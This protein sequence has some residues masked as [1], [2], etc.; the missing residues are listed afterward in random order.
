[1]RAGKSSRKELRHQQD[2]SFLSVDNTLDYLSSPP[3]P[4]T[5]KLHSMSKQHS[6]ILKNYTNGI[7]ST[8]SVPCDGSI[9]KNNASGG[10]SASTKL[11]T[12]TQEQFHNWAQI[13]SC[14][15]EKTFYPSTESQIIKI[16][17]KAKKYNKKLK[18]CGSGHSPS[19]IAMCDSKEDWMVH[20]SKY[21]GITKI[22]KNL[23]QIKGGTTLNEVNAFLEKK[24]KCLSSLG[25]ISEQTISGAI[26]TGTH[27]TG[28]SY[29]NLCSMVEMMRIVDASGH[30][31]VAKKGDELWSAAVCGLGAVG[32]ICEVTF[33]VEPL[34][35]LYAIQKPMP[36]DHVLGNLNDL[37]NSAEHYRFWWFPHT[38]N[39]ISWSANRVGM[40]T[41][42]SKDIQS[43]FENFYEN[44]KDK[45]IGYHLFEF[46]L[47][48][49]R[50]FPSLVPTIN[51]FYYYA[52]F[53]EAKSHVDTS[54]RVFNF[55]C[56]FK[57]YVNEWA[58]PI[59]RTKEALLKLKQIIKEEDFK[60]H[61]PVEVRFVKRDN[62]WMSPSYDRDVCYIGIIMY[63][64]YGTD[65]PYEKYFDAFEKLMV[66]LDGRPH[67]AKEFS[68]KKEDFEKMYPKF[69]D[70]NRVRKKMD[71]NGMFMNKYLRRALGDE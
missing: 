15:A 8:P 3:S 62:I 43:L 6:L 4:L 38:N 37:I 35:K 50:H 46:T 33:L 20:L 26:S 55:D 56:R 49:G 42:S 58:I 34:F 67:W 65:V 39:C 44:M 45:W 2:A 53:S 54:F 10:K 68:L 32:I 64:P 27:G 14:T 7:V 47:Y 19:D 66:S 29:G 70:F 21:T 40:Q 52:L 5:Q 16:V 51:R 63:R 41:K 25:S 31:R 60:V 9:I 69:H 18:V 23:V 71:P 30:I 11:E 12:H 59:E 48:L 28:I 17:K 1:M 36:L 57:Q 13:H 24:G 61:L 22:D